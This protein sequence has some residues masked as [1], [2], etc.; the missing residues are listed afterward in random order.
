MYQ[1]GLNNWLLVAFTHLPYN[2]RFTQ[3]RLFT[4]K[5][6]AV[7]ICTR[8]ISGAFY[9]LNFSLRKA[10][11]HIGSKKVK[12]K[13][14]EQNKGSVL[15]IKPIIMDCAASKKYFPYAMAK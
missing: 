7:G 12:K 9:V 13:L 8:Y 10:E 15:F 5:V 6:S 4:T 2:S 1:I 3:E 14:T 11:T